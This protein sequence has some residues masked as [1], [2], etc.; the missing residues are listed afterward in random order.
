MKASISI[1]LR[2]G[3][4]CA[5]SIAAC[6]PAASLR[7]IYSEVASSPTSIVPGALDAAGQPVVTSWN[8]LAV[9]GLSVRINGDEWVVRGTTTQVTSLDN[10]LVRGAGNTGT[11]FLQEGQPLQGGGEAGETYSFFDSPPVHFNASGQIAYSFRAA[12]GVTTNDEKVATCIGGT[13][14]IILSQG[15][16]ITGLAHSCSAIGNSVGSV[17]M[18]DSGVVAFGNTPLTGCSSAIYYPAL[19]HNNVGVMQNNVTT[20]TSGQ[21]GEE[22][23]DGF[24]YDGAAFSPDGQHI[25]IGATTNNPNTA[26]D[27]ILLL[28]TAAIMREGS[29]IFS[30]SAVMATVTKTWYAPNGDWYARGTQS[31][32]SLPPPAGTDDWA[33]RNG[34]LLARTGGPITTGSAETWGDVISSFVGNGHGDYIVV[35]N[36]SEPNANANTVIVRNATDV[37]VREG[38]PV[39]VNANNLPDDDAYIN[40]FIGNAV[41]L[42]NDNILYIQCTLRNGA[43]T[44]LGDALL[45]ADVAPPA[46]CPADIVADGQVNVGDLLAVI[47]GWGACPAPCPP[48]CA[49]D[50]AP[51]PAGDCQVNVADLLSVISSWGPCP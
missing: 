1:Q 31:S 34:V 47:T 14:T 32:T 38:D 12:G 4:C 46:D 42:T 2:V 28:D 18:L 20:I 49:A 16:A 43:G 45:R 11:M 29:A 9:P 51:V 21:V 39:D 23:V 44:N 50:I 13:N 27:A 48:R 6:A 7:V 26:A 30:T 35:G 22:V 36:T 8:S 15:S 24:S 33:V 40:A 37:L 25:L 41:F 17:H 5:M 19:F 10:I 3:A